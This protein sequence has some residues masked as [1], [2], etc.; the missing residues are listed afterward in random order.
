MPPAAPKVFLTAEWRN[1]AMLNYETEPSV[2]A[3]FVPAGT[4][5]DSWQ[6]RTYVSIVAFLF[7]RTRVRGAPIP[8]HQNFEEVNLRFYVRRLSHEGWRR[9][10][11]FIKELVPRFAIA[12][13]ARQFYN[14]NY[15]A[16]PMRHHFEKHQGELKSAH[17]CWRYRGQE[18]YVK[19]AIAGPAKPLADGSAE[20]FITEHYWGYARQRDGSTMEYRVD[21][22]RWKV[23]QA[24]HIEFHCQA[25]DL[26]GDKF[27]PFLSAPPASAFLADGSDVKVYQGVKLSQ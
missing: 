7:L 20:E 26:Y 13:I 19:L 5:L 4:E 6:G 11:V 1:L 24:Q 8:F 27:A 14:E 3:P 18:N 10:V 9:G 17:Y 12:F 23:W 22:P 25:A 16:V 21:H 2:L 15:L